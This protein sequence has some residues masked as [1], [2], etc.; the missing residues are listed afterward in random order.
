MND[1]PLPSELPDRSTPMP[2]EQAPLE[3]DDFPFWGYTDLLFVAL[4]F[5][6]ALLF[7]GLLA[8]LTGARLSAKMLLG[9][10]LFVY[11]AG[12]LAMYA[13]IVMRYGR[14]F[15]GAM[16]WAAT[17]AALRNGAVAG[18]GTAI[19]TSLLG[20]LVGTG[21]M[22][23]LPMKDV[24]STKAMVAIVGLLAVTLGPLW[25]ELTFRGF[26]LPL[27]AKSMGTP[28]AI[29]TTAVLFA[30][31]HGQEYGWGWRELL[32]IAFAGACFGVARAVSGSTS[33]A[34]TMHAI[35]NLT[36]FSAF[37]AQGGLNNLK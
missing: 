2:G 36:I 19:G 28:V 25:E 8:G 26:L 32:P 30:L 11:A 31:L 1:W 34:V 13:V 9:Q 14:S 23:D 18:I 27:F 37:I 20:A 6:F 24:L 35:Y 7:L 16:R 4:L 3:P 5:V 21:H 33:V 22:K 10:Q 15:A 29:F 17:N 12:V